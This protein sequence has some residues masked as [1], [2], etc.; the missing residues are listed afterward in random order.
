MIV[1]GVLDQRAA[2]VRGELRA[3]ELEVVGGDPERVDDAAVPA[4]EPGAGGDGGAQAAQLVGQDVA[5]GPALDHEVGGGH[6]V[7]V[8]VG[9]ERP[10][11]DDVEVVLAQERHE[12]LG[13]L[14]G[15]VP[16]PPATDDEG[17]ALL[18]HDGFS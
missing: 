3:D 15:R 5:H 12:Q 16:V 14:L 11:D 1:D 8:R 10:L 17:S 13:G 9:L 4:G 2:G 18:G 6:E 7:G